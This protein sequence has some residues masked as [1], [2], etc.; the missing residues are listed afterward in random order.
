M[1]VIP[2]TNGMSESSPIPLRSP[3]QALILRTIRDAGSISRADIARATGL[4][5]PTATKIVGELLQADLVEETGTGKSEGGRPP[6][7]LSLNATSY[8]I[9]GVDLARTGIH[10]ILTDL[11]AQVINRVKA[12]SSLSHPI[13][14]TLET[15]LGLITRLIDESSVDRSRILGIGIGAP[16]PLSS[17]EGL[18]ISPPNFSGWSNVP[19]RQIVEA[20]FDIPTYVDN[21]ANAC[22]LAEKWFGDGQPYDRF[23]YIAAGT[24]TGAGVIIDGELDRGANDIAWE[25]GHTTIDVNGPRCGCGNYG[26]LELYTSGAAVVERARHALNYG[27]QSKILELAGDDTDA[28]TLSMVI[29]AG[30][31]GDHLAELV[32]EETARYLAV[33]VVNA[34]NLFDPEVVFI[35]REISLAGD[36]LLGPIRQTVAERAFSV[37]AERVKV[38]PARLKA[39]A[40]VI[41]AIVLVLRELFSVPTRQGGRAA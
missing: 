41:G 14:I 17:S 30:L 34:I 24:G 19:L 3:T 2:G 37:A 40:P 27:Q 13:D 38:L 22:A 6:I 7:L 23:I 11:N 36:L 9:I 1:K 12:D 4:T 20:E 28:I 10:G 18:I 8:F 16:G 39:D 32:L 5:A 26:C 35:G 31:A 33:G 15:L 29:E 21:D 25:L